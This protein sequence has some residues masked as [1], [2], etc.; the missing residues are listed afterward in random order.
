MAWGKDLKVDT[1]SEPGGCHYLYPLPRPQ[2][3][4]GVG[5]MVEGD[6]FVRI[7]VD[8]ADIVAPGGGKRGMSTDDIRRLY[9]GRVEASPH[10]YTDGQYLRIQDAA[11]G[12]GVLVFETDEAGKVGDWHIGVPPQV[13]YVEGCS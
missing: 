12:N 5:F 3:G 6:K 10:E 1:P 11:G 7:D 9:L 2:G 13:D 4:Y 8:S